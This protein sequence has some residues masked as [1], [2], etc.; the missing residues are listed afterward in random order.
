LWPEAGLIGY[1]PIEMY[2]YKVKKRAMSK[3]IILILSLLSY[4][5]ISGMT[6]EK[7]SEVLII[8]TIHGAH[9]TNPNYSFDTLFKFV[10]KFNPDI[11]GVEIRAEDIDSS[12]T[13]MKKNYPFEM[14]ECIRKYPS[15]QISGFDWLG[16]DIEGK[17]IPDR[18]WKEV[19]IIKK[20][21]Q[22]LSKDSAI[23]AKISILDIIQEEKDHLALNASLSELN[24][25]RY[26]L[27]NRVYYAQL[28]VL[29]HAT[30]YEALSD[31]Y[32]QRDE[33]IAHNILDIIKNNDGKRMIF[34]L[35][36]DH[37]DYTLKKVS[38]EM[39]NQILLN[40]FK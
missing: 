26:D 16:S 7:K 15:K 13:Y 8:S 28:K 19:S 1:L 9:R 37:R 36:A 35:G 21:Q 12:F 38:D 31:F 34:L 22:E 4:L 6:Q 29:L 30:A 11:I 40:H 25:G 18:Y 14:Y 24:D 10:E 39:G 17:A 23:L 33:H 3:T 27:I 20:L 2:N 32:Q 5:P